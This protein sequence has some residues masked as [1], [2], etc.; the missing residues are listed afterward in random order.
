MMNYVDMSMINKTLINVLK[1][2]LNK[3]HR[4]SENDTKIHT[5]TND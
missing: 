3:A 4:N 1:K 2:V 5:L